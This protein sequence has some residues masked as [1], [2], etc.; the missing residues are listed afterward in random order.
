MPQIPRVT[1]PQDKQQ[2]S[3]KVNDKLYKE[4]Q[5][6]RELERRIRD[7]KRKQEAFKAAGLTEAADNQTA[8]VRDRQA[9]M[10]AFIARTGRARRYD[11]E[12]VRG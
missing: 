9:A 10:R 6:Q 8:I 5:E 2:E 3:Q 4:S 11:R 1:I 7:A 12:S